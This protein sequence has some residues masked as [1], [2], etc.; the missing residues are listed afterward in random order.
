MD[1][2]SKSNINCGPKQIL[3]CALFTKHW[4]IVG[5]WKHCGDSLSRPDTPLLQSGGVG[6][7]QENNISTKTKHFCQFGCFQKHYRTSGIS[8]TWICFI[9]GDSLSR[10]D[11][12]SLQSG[13]VGWGQPFPPK[14]L[15]QLSPNQITHKDLS[16]AWQICCIKG[17]SLSR[18]DTPLLQ[19]GGV[20]WGG[21]RRTT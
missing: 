21:D 2:S 14:H 5:Q 10:P 13:G 7:G 18:P 3:D 16:L 17:N 19:S 11:T 15:C 8:L 9:K 6:C 20:G 4:V 1:K 12:P